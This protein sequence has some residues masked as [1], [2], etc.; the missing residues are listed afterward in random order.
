MP[1]ITRRLEFDAG[2][3]IHGHEN[4]CAN[5]HGHRYVAEITVSSPELDGI[6]RVVDFNVLKTIVGGWIDTYW[7]HNI[8]LHPNDPILE[9]CDIFGSEAKRSIFGRK[10]PYIMPVGNPTAENMVKTLA[11]N[12]QALLSRLSGEHGSLYK[13]EAVRLY[14]TPN[15]WADWKAN[16]A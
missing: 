8:L 5:L 3:R 1:L 10:L 12:A 7:D 11:T 14:E 2:H 13:V 4:K 16:D 9:M 6:G 15:C